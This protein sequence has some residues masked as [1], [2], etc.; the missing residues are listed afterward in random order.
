MT[1]RARRVIAGLEV[2]GGVCGTLTVG[3]EMARPGFPRAALGPAGVLIAVFLLS[4]FA[5][6]ML[7]RDTR[8]GR[9]ASV[10]VQLVQLPKILS[11]ELSFMVSFGLDAGVMFVSGP[12]G[13]GVVFKGVVFHSWVGSH[14]VLMTGA[15]GGPTA[16]GFS[17]VSCVALYIL[18]RRA[19]SAETPGTT[20]TAETG[21]AGPPSHPD[22]VPTFGMKLVIGLVVLVLVLCGSCLFALSLVP[23]A[24][25][26]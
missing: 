17:L 19:D 13:K 24:P 22:W 4:L 23:P 6:V 25:R 8:T 20:P 21:A 15:P 18:L 10:V 9:V 7:W 1:A 2:I 12:I 5:G 3:L 26:D 16:F 14:H 11:A